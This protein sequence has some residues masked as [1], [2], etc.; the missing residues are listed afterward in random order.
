MTRR[1]GPGRFTVGLALQGAGWH[2]AAWT[3]LPRGD[4]ARL[5]EL[6][7]W[8]DLVQHAE[9]AGIDYV[10]FEDAYQIEGGAPDWE[11]PRDLAEVSLDATLLAASLAPLTKRIGLVPTIGL[12]H[13]EPFHAATSIQTLDHVS[14]GRAG[15]RAKLSASAAEAASFGRKSSLGLDAIFAE[16]TDAVE[17]IRRLWDSWED[18]AVIR[19]ESTGRFIDADRLHYA[20]FEG[21]HFSVKGPSIVPRSPQGQPPVF[22][23]A[24]AEES[25]DFAARQADVVFITP[26]RSTV[27]ELVATIR[28]AELRVGRTGEPL[29]IVADLEIF[30]GD[31]DGSTEEHF[32]AL[33]ERVRADSGYRSDTRVV[34]RSNVITAELIAKYAD[35]GLDGVRVRPLTHGDVAEFVDRVRPMLEARG[36]VAPP[37]PREKSP[38]LRK[39]FG[40]VPRPANRFAASHAERPGTAGSAATRAPRSSAQPAPARKAHRA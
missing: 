27:A 31:E 4:G 5:T 28:D 34:V 33:D 25:F 30:L 40:L 26:G 21:E 24:Q 38:S 11:A 29:R 7:Y 8:R 3:V 14:L 23:L 12:T 10:T 39:T 20:D 6:G 37:N 15:L 13:A 2:P 1:Q 32:R 22:A 18:D 17:V 16:G 36:I 9:R 19:D 35:A